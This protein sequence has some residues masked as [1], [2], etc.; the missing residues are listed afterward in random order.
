MFN[1]AQ[2]LKSLFQTATVAQTIDHSDIV[3]IATEVYSIEWGMVVGIDGS[4][5]A[6][7]FFNETA[8]DWQTI[9]VDASAVELIIKGD[10]FF[11][12]LEMFY[13]QL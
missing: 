11:T 8:A 7:S 13:G 9:E 2:T 5:V 4:A 1:V 10:E 3:A 12:D 6:V